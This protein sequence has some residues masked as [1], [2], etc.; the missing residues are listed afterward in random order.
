MS[1]RRLCTLLAFLSLPT[2]AA[3]QSVAGTWTSPTPRGAITLTLRVSDG[4]VNGTLVGNG[5]SMTVKGTVDA[6]EAFG[7]VEGGGGTAIFTAH[8]EGSRLNFAMTENGANGQPSPGT[9]RELI[10]TRSGNGAEPMGAAA[11]A[12]SAGGR[13]ANPLGGSTAGGATANPL[14]GGGGDPIEGT[15]QSNDLNVVVTRGAQGYSGVLFMRGEEYPFTATASGTRLSGSFA[16]AGQRYPFESRLAGDE[17]TLASGGKD[18]RMMRKGAATPSA[19]R[20]SGGM[21]AAAAAAPAPASGGL[22]LVGATGV[23]ERQIAQLLV[24]SAWCYMSYS[25]GSTY[26]GGSYGRTNT[27][28]VVFAADGNGTTTAGGENSNSG[29][30]GSVYSQGSNGQRFMWKVQGMNLVLSQDG[31]QWSPVP[32]QIYDNGSGAPIVKSQGKEYSRCS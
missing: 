6:D 25:G 13:G 27:Q 29:G 28:R 26:T 10:F 12:P 20:T 2:I 17:M 1:F 32:L 30:N 7:T 21:P 3:A 22:G 14:G 19:P 15:F 23:Q 5:V 8:V 16:A 4:A 24:S 9:A 31:V 11:P 18:Y